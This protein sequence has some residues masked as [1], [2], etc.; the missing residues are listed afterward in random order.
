MTD[1]IK[2][3]DKYQNLRAE[4]EIFA[5]KFLSGERPYMIFQTPS[6]DVWGDI[7]TPGQSFEKNMEYIE[8]SLCIPS[9]HLPILE[10]WFGTGVFANM[11]GCPYVFRDGQ[12]PAV[13]YKYHTPDEIIGLPKPSWQ[14]GEIAGLVLDTIKYFK[15]KTGDAIPIVWTDTQSASDTA[16]LILDASEVFIACMLEPEVIMKFMQDIN[17]LT[18]E[19]SQV[20][21]E[22]IGNALIEPGHI[23]LSNTGFRGLSIADDNLAVASPSVNRDFNLALDEEIGRAFGGVAIHSCGQWTHTMP[24]LKKEVPSCV[25]IDCAVDISWDPNPNKPEEVRDAMAGT[26][27]HVHA[28]TSGETDKMLEDV[29][30]LFHPD[31]KLIVHPNFIDFK[32]AQRNYGEL[33]KLLKRLYK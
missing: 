17:K 9:E 31:L 14:N 23:M 26:G 18:I 20:Q 2:I 1:F 32:T 22:Y 16:T 5:Q 7:R 12:P 24:M 15:E 28:R 10:P 30:R 29:K 19:F 3:T 33:D 11:Y 25:A 8:T 6:G 27:I 13:H 4:R 21:A